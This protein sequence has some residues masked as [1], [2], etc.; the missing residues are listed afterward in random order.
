[1]PRAHALALEDTLPA[2]V[3]FLLRRHL[4][5]EIERH[6]TRAETRSE[7]AWE[8]LQQGKE[9][10]LTIDTALAAGD[11]ARAAR[12]LARADS[13]FAA[14]AAADGAW[15][16][17]VIERGWLSWQERHIAGF[18]K[19]P[20]DRWTRA[21]LGFAGDALRLRPGDPE[22]LHLRGTM[23]YA[24][25]FLNLNPAPQTPDQ[26]LA[27]AE[28]DLRAG[29]AEANP[30]R[31]NALALLSQLLAA[32]SQT[33]DAKLTAM[34]AYEVDP[35]QSQAEDVLTRLFLTSLDLEDVAESNKWCQEGFRR[36]PDS[37]QFT[38]C[39]IQVYALKGQQPDVPALWRLL[40]RNVA[41]YPPA[42]REY[43]RRRGELFVAM[44][45]AN[46]GMKDSARAVALR[47]RAGEDIDPT[48]D[49][50]YVEI[51]FRS[52]AGDRDEAIRLLKLYLVTNPQ[53]K[54]SIAADDTWWL[55]ELHADPEFRRIVGLQK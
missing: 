45:L 31:A 50:V 24:R 29:A 21:G 48:R 14:S 49:L 12:T 7:R 10:A 42:D 27:A 36:F 51:L 15:P 5:Q 30:N 38:E 44:A 35:Y 19:G 26:L 40:E 2:Q 9:T 53:A 34:Q 3:A 23:R 1:V 37:P 4:G 33:V 11:T 17:P 55:R 47:A 41:Q 20:A 8:L 54:A 16:A 28:A 32:R 46:A 13:L 25:W 39:Q 22:A 18:D 52:M 43:R 6:A